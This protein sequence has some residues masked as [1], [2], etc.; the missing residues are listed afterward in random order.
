M[1]I[2]REPVSA[3]NVVALGLVALF[4]AYITFSSLTAD[5]A[6]DTGIGAEPT[7]LQSQPDDFISEPL[8]MP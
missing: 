8:G 1:S 6:I 5:D 3:L 4:V 2:I 7:V